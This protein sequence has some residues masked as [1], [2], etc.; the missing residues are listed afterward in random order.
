MCSGPHY[1][2]TYASEAFLS[3]PSPAG[4][5]FPSQSGPT[6]GSFSSSS[7]S[8]SAFLF[9]TPD[10]L[11]PTTQHGS[12]LPPASA[13]SFDPG[14]FNPVTA[15]GIPEVE[16]EAGGGG[17]QPTDGGSTGADDDGNGGGGAAALTAS[18]STAAQ[19]DEPAP[20]QKEP[21]K[22]AGGAVKRELRKRLGA[23]LGGGGRSRSRRA[24]G[25]YVEDEDGDGSVEGASA[26]DDDAGHSLSVRTSLL[27]ALLL[28]RS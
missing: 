16:M 12:R 13:F 18:S 26:S 1:D 6:Y 20:A 7:P 23:A 5:L 24:R 2:P 9:Q 14:A 27:L 8:G 21:R 28:V 15:F 11:R 25:A 4:A 3:R 22:L 19:P 10:A 17:G